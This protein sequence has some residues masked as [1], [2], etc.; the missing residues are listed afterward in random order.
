M[1]DTHQT[2]RSA[3]PD[4]P[5]RNPDAPRRYRPSAKR[6]ANAERL[7]Q[8]LR[9]SAWSIFARQGLEG[10]TIAAIVADSGLATGSFYNHY[11]TKQAVF[12][13]LMAGLVT[14]IRRITA[15]ARARA[16]DLGT[17]L[18]LSYRD[19]LDYILTL[20]GALSFIA[21]NQHHIRARLY[22]L[23][24]T[25]GLLDDLR[26]DV[27]RGL[28]GHA[29]T[30]DQLSLIAGLIVAN[31]LETLLLLQGREGGDTAAL[32]DLMTG[33]LMNGINGLGARL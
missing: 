12:D 31:G 25:G 20:E 11:G 23:D 22:G 14:D 29:P 2:G 24:S 21:R 28:A 3:S 1:R 13:D 6:G 17:M 19:L 5:A 16:D 33:L 27:A 30:P 10:A 7:R 4:C 9:Q 15:A 26:Q 8:R 18:R 32:A